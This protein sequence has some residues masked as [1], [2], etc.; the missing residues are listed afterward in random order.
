MIIRR[1]SSIEQHVSDHVTALRAKRQAYEAA[2]PLRAKA[3]VERMRACRIAMEAAL[4]R[5]RDS[6]GGEAK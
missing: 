1:G 2:A 4:G 3:Q 6:S 5:G